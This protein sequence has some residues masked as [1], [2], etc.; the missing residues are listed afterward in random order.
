ME[1]VNT[2]PAYRDKHK[3][4][5]L[6]YPENMSSE[7]NYSGGASARL[8]LFPFVGGSALAYKPWL[9]Q[10][11]KSIEAFS[12][13][14]PGRGIRFSEPLC[15]NMDEIVEDI[16]PVLCE[17]SDKPLFFFGHSLG[18]R[19]AYA[20]C[21]RLHEMKYPLP[22]KVFIS[23]SKS[24][25]VVLERQLHKLSNFDL[26]SELS[27]HGGLPQIFLDNLASLEHYMPLIR[28]D[29][30]IF[31]NYHC[32]AN[33]I[34]PTQLGVLVGQKDTFLTLDQVYGWN[35]YFHVMTD[36]KLFMGGHFYIY[37]EAP[38]LIN[39]L[40]ENILK[41]QSQLLSAMKNPG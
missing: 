5:T 3:Y 35:R 8:I 22:K 7:E 18:G 28:S 29:M 20:C 39:Y 38:Q 27:K 25:D 14:L 13:Q 26:I 6:D 34:I 36:S 1:R 19:I 10:F 40:T 32:E 21:R 4:I 30:A 2:L 23:A 17:L 9:S 41:I 24:P 37:D 11:P 12:V 33:K 16:I 31:E 15:S